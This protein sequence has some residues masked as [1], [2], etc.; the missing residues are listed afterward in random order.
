MKIYKIN[1]LETDFRDYGSF[2]IIKDDRINYDDIF[3]LGWYWLSQTIN[4]INIQSAE[5]TLYNKNKNTFAFLTSKRYYKPPVLTTIYRYIAEKTYMNR[6]KSY[7]REIDE[8]GFF[9][10]D[11]VKFYTDAT[12]EGYGGKIFSLKNIRIEPFSLHL[13]MG[14]IFGPRLKVNTRTD[15]DVI[16]SL[17]GFFLKEPISPQRVLN[18]EIYF[19][20]QEKIN[21]ETI[22]LIEMLSKMAKVD[23]VISEEETELI[24][25]FIKTNLK[26]EEASIKQIMKNFDQEKPT[27][28]SFEFHAREYM[29]IH[30]GN[31]VILESTL[32]TLFALSLADGYLSAEE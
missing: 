26:Y 18:G 14:K 25:N 22:H 11:D 21:K 27:V 3:S 13:D 15:G 4:F 16:Q 29:Q 7:T 17:I 2:F 23:G 24:Y 20:P 9:S 19:T 5:L 12:V 10:Y 31:Y 1:N 30:R 6:L 8:K 28:S 32:N